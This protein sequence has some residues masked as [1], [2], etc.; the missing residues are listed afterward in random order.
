MTSDPIRSQEEQVREHDKDIE[1]E[2]LR[3]EGEGGRAPDVPYSR[4]SK[5]TQE[6]P[7]TIIV[8]R[9]IVLPD[10]ED[11]DDD[12]DATPLE[13]HQSFDMSCII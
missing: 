13:E 10:D 7:E 11:E 12:P 2:I 5:V 9:A 3:M 4:P 6:P 1:Q 8:R